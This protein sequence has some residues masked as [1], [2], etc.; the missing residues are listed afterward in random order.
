[1]TG[2][3]LIVEDDKAV[4]AALRLGFRHEGWTVEGGDDGAEGLRLATEKKYDMVILDVMLPK[5]SGLDL[6]QQLRSA[7]H[8]VPI[9]ILT[10]R[11]QE[12]D[13]VVGLKLGADDYVTKPFSFMELL[14]RVE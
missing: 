12:V 1:M 14:A 6:C 13:K 5:I 3:I 8:P 2:K 9:I 4:A 11:G 10:A 7:G